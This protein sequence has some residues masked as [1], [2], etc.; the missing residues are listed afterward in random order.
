M[1]NYRSNSHKA[2]AEAK[3]AAEKKVD[4]VV[5]GNVK[6]KKKSEVSKFKD[7]FISEDVSN[8]KSYIFLDVLVP[9]IKKAVSDIVKDG[10]DMMLYGDKRS[11]SRGS[12]SYVSYRSYSDNTSR[13][14]RRSVRASYDF[15]DVVFDTRGEADEVLSSMDELMD[16]YG[17]VSVADM[18]DLCGM[19]CNY[20]DNKYG[21]KSL[22]RADISRV[23]DGYIIKLPKAEPILGGF[24]E[25]PKEI[26]LK[27]EY[28]NKFDE[29]RKDLVVQSYFKYGKASRNFVSGYVDAIGSLKKCI[30][31]FEETGNLEYL[32]DAANYCMFRY[33]YPQTG[34]YFKHT[35]SNE[36]AGIDGMS[37]KEIEEFKKEN[38]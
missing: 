22:A 15:D 26:I 17:V 12:S 16:R 27:T 36:S 11:G 28:S 33:M 18:Y 14:S 13:N 37:V 19:T 7:V 9:A 23:R 32:A 20:T 31:K 6:R 24:M 8:V 2:K 21:W 3:E 35:D 1:E 34:E 4:K 10:I 29:I 38:E 30:Q 5:T 25:D